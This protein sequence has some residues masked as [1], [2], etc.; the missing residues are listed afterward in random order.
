[1]KITERIDGTN[2]LGV[3]WMKEVVPYPKS[4]KVSLDDNCQFRC[5]FCASSTQK[6]KARMDRGMFERLVEELVWGGVEELGLFFI[7]EP[8]LSRDLEWGIR[9]AKELGIGYVFLT[10]NGAL[11]TRERLEPLM[12]AGLDSLKFSFNYADGE[13]LSAV[14]NVS[15][16]NFFKI[17]KNIEDA[18]KLRDEKGYKC[19]IYASSIKF[20]GE[21]QERM[22]AAV[23]LI[24]PFVDEHYWLP[25]Y[26][27]GGQTEF[28]ERVMGNPGRLD[29]PRE[30]LPC[31]AIF[32]E[33]HVTADGS[34]SL[35]CFDVHDRWKAGDLK[36]Q[37]FIEAWNSPVAQELR[38]AH[39]KKDVRGT[40]CENCAMGV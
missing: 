8:M 31:W 6:E 13:Q 23:G 15:W 33:G 11:A 26:S 29:N 38:R 40:S 4:V 2:E 16:R 20:D 35:C 28:G 12:E 1:M 39:L 7:G 21:Q 5:S 27:F 18:R 30:P 19:G 24:R 22:E 10:T 37:T 14:A 32:K 25:Q 3:E 34:V 36:T 17:V 9:R